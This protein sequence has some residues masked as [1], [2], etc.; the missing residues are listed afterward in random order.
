MKIRTAIMA[1][2]LSL[3]AV[4]VS[5]V[6]N[7]CGGGDDEEFRGAR[8]GEACETTNDCASGLACVPGASSG[9]GTCVLGV[10]SV[11]PTAKECAITEC[12]QVS[13]CCGP[14]PSSC[15]GL[16]T[17]CLSDAGSSSQAACIQYDAL[18]KCDEAKRGC[19][20]SRCVTKCSTNTDCSGSGRGVCAGGRCVQCGTDSDCGGGSLKCVSGEC[21]APC[22]GDGDCPGFERC[23]AGQCTD[24]ACQSDRECVAATA[25][26]EAKCGT[27]NKCIVPCQTDLECGSPKSYKFFSC[28]SGQCQYLGCETD[29]ECRLL[30]EGTGTSSSSGSTGSS[31]G[32]SGS[33]T[34]TRHIVC[35]EK[36]TPGT[37]TTP[38]R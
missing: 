32:S 8:K 11:A 23:L 29:K 34:P 31:S 10:F 25:N 17:Q 30:L 20:N 24:G 28:V 16:L 35:R 19:E 14:P 38:A 33:F 4:L 27:D 15:P 7:G 13:D 6:A 18:C 22:Q 37:T 36:Q 12:S 21:K 26:V 1:S 9:G 3:G 2:G 5:L